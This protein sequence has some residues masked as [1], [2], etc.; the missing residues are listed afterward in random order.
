MM[1]RTKSPRKAA[2]TYDQLIR[3]QAYLSRNYHNRIEDW[4]N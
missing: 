1:R 2:K 3:L 4:S